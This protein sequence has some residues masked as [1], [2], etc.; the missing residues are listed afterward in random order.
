MEFRLSTTSRPTTSGAGRS[1][2]PAATPATKLVPPAAPASLVG[3]ERLLERLDEALERRLTTIVADAGFGKSTLL[4]SWSAR[5]HSAWYGIAQEDASL[6]A[7]A[8]GLVDALRLRVPALP[9]DIGGAL[10]GSRGP[11]T[12]ADELARARGFA[13]LVCQALQDQLSR[14]LVLVLDD[15]HELAEDSAASRLIEALCRQAPTRLHLVLVSRSEPPFPVDRLRGQGQ[16]L[17]L[18]GSDLAFTIDE[19]ASLLAELAGHELADA[20]PLVHAATSGW[21]AGVRLA[22]ET[23]RGV[24]REGRAAALE[25]IR[26]PG[27]SLFAYLASEVFAN[28]PAEVTELVRT[29][30]PLDRFTPELCEALGI[31][32]ASEILA[33]LARRGLFVEVH[34][35]DA[36]WYTLGAPVREF[37]LAHLRPD[38]RDV[39]RVRDQAAAWLAEHGYLE[40]ALR[41][42]IDRVDGAEIARFLGEHG[43]GLIARGAIEPVVASLDLVPLELRTERIERIAGDA[44]QVQGTWDEALRCFERAAVGHTQLPP[45]LAWR[46]GQIHYLR[47]HL[48]EAL[49]V[50]GRASS[51]GEPRDLALLLAWRASAHWLRGSVDECRQDAAQAFELAS[52]AG[53]P[54]A[55]AATHTVLAM[56]AALEGD[57]GANDAHYLRA[58]DYAEQADDVL[59]LVRVRTNRGSRH[60]EEG[61]YEEAVAELDLALRLADLAAFASFRGLALSNRGEARFRL[62]RLEE[63]VADL[64]ESRRLYERLG[65]RMVAYPLEK[66]GVIYRERGDVTLARAAFEESVA[67]AEDAGDLQ[68]LVPALAGLAQVIASD[69]PEEAERLVERALSFDTAMGHVMALLADGWIALE[70]GDRSHAAARALEAASA[71][72]ARRDRAALA[73]SLELRVLAAPNPSDE[74]E[75]LDEARAIWASLDNPIGTTRVD[76]LAALLADDPVRARETEAR[77]R[78]LGAHRYRAQLSRLLPRDPGPAVA[79]QSLGRFRVYRNGEPIPLAAWQSRKA[80]DLLKM[81][82]SRRGRPAPRDL[83]METLWPEQSPEELGRRLSVLLSTVR[84]VLDPDKEHDPEH[85]VAADKASIWLQTENVTADV[86]RFLAAASAAL[87]AARSGERGAYGRLAAA[88]ASYTGDFLEEDAYEDWAANLR[89]E[90]RAT[91][92]ELARV[93]AGEAVEGGDADAATRYYL[94]VL[95]RDPYDEPAHLGLVGALETAGRHGEARR[96]FRAYCARMDEIGVESAPFPGVAV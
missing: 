96:C 48:D 44:H 8:R 79:I 86:E 68:G 82:L 80:R 46:M 55:L 28:E 54:Q 65:S 35:R 93:L 5:V 51:D 27:G 37:A 94:R 33:S 41:A 75:R 57:R 43:D 63:A 69:E 91:Y 32:R 66:L 2:A 19:T 90:A 12:D 78:E 25:R 13:A 70:R 72:H 42:L 64:E 26:R 17:E 62:G 89:E 74:S 6:A 23:L 84:S 30:A 49:E 7:F 50:Y 9:G 87:A 85:F 73:E 38:P 21:P 40:E 67:Q 4:A 10:A 1:A 45:G 16:V 92:V 60:F 52:A 58:L 18:S 71:A 88:E 11:G 56:L 34:G 76:L 36:A 31:S 77:L 83:L 95:E 61:A 81:L 22:V 20:A 14:D 53:D 39:E 59:Q 3:R 29:V 47:G 24:P 15:V